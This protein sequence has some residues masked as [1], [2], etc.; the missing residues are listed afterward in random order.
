MD[1]AFQYVMSISKQSHFDDI[2]SCYPYKA[3]VRF[4]KNWLDFVTKHAPIQVSKGPNLISSKNW[5][6]NVAKS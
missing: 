1:Q 6:L 4:L 2:E 5:R 3:V